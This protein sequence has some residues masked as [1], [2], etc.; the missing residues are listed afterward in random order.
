[1]NRNSVIVDGTLP[2]SPACS[3]NPAD[4]D[5]GRGLGRRARSAGTGSTSGPTASRVDNLTVCNFQ[6]VE[7]SH[8]NQAGDGG[9]EI[10]WD[11][12]DNTGKIGLQGYEGSY[13]TATDTF[14]GAVGGGSAAGNYGIFSGES[15]GPGVWNQVY[16]NNFADSGMYIGACQQVCDAW[17]NNAWM[18]NNALGYSGTNSGGTAGDRTLAVRRQ[19]RRPRHQHPER[20]RSAT[21]AERRL[22]VRWGQRLHPHP[23]V[24]GVH[25][26]RSS[27]NNNNPR[28]PG[29][30]SVAASRS[31]RA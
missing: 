24:L 15:Q 16:A 11:G 3:S 30:R 26:Q 14:N 7:D 25:G 8:G 31:G 13:L 19:H 20:R 12:G 5:L 29:G 6:L 28:A 10:W 23:F 17:I 27:H 2:G 4:Q 18:E 1:M 22:P 21:A 9:N